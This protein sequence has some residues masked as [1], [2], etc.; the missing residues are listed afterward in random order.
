MLLKGLVKGPESLIL[1]GDTFYT[2]TIDGKILQVKDGQIMDFIEL[3]DPICGRF[4][5]NFYRSFRKLRR[6]TQM[7]KSPWH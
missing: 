2:G 7:R 1:D 6:F 4:K 3:G 5:A